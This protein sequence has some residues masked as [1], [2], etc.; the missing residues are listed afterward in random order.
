MSSNNYFDSSL[1]FN[2][3][4]ANTYEEILDKL[5]KMLYERNI[6]KEEFIV[7]IKEREDNFPTGLEC[8]E[9]NVAVPHS[10]HIYVN[11]GKV[12]FAKLKNP[13]LFNKMDDPSQQIPVS[14]IIMLVVA[15]PKAHIDLLQK[16]F[17]VIQNQDLLKR[18]VE[19]EEQDDLIKIVQE[20]ILGGE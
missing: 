13:V 10:D 20:N 15:E 3:F 5:S 12:V 18:I 4:E 16:V 19:T 2:N 9:I 17:G 7:K 6:V 1:V 8:G 11:E 14:I